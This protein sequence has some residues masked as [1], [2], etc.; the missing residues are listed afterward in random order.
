MLT[1]IDVLCI[2]GDGGDL[3]CGGSGGYCKLL[4]SLIIIDFGGSTPNR[5]IEGLKW[6]T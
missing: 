4:I 1:G 2:A 6:Q 5:T 3:G